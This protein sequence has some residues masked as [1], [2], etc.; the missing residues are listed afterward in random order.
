VARVD[1]PP[2]R[3]ADFVIDAVLGTGARGPV[4]PAWANALRDATHE[5]WTRVIALDLPTGL[6]ADTGR[7]LEGGFVQRADLTVAFAHLKPAHVLYPGRALC[8]TIEVVDIGVEPASGIQLATEEL[9]ASLLPRRKPTVHKGEAGRVLAVGGSAGL[10]GAIVLA[11]MSALRAGAG[12]VTAAVPESVNDAI[13]SAM[14]E[15][16][17]W[18][19][20]EAPERSLG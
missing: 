15:A 18:P 4:P 10:T 13:E 17:T 20:P 6:D 11:A 1:R 3:P 14:I 5:P 2:A 12:Y 7:P 8:G 9:V 16:M 19:L